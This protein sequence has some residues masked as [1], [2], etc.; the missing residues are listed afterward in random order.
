MIKNLSYMFYSA[1]SN[2]SDVSKNKLPSKLKLIIETSLKLLDYKL[3]YFLLSLIETIISIFDY[4][5][6]LF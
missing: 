1:T 5:F 6:F 2:K 4:N 3:Y